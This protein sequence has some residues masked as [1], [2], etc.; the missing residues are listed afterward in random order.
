[1]LMKCWNRLCIEAAG[2]ILKLTATYQHADQNE[3]LVMTLL[4]LTTPD[5]KLF[6]QQA[7]FHSMCIRF[8]LSIPFP[9][10]FYN[11]VLH[12][13]ILSDFILSFQIK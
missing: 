11:S 9:F 12:A 3:S 8:S 7:G 6:F 10:F 13:L 2:C 5:L 1:M 4:E